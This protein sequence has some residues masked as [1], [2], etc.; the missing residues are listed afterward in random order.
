MF[1]IGERSIGDGVRPVGAAD[2]RLKIVVRRQ[3]AATRNWV[4]VKKKTP[5]DGMSCTVCH[6]TCIAETKESLA[7]SSSRSSLRASNCAM[8]YSR[9]LLLRQHDVAPRLI[10]KGV[11][12]DVARH[13]LH[14]TIAGG[15]RGAICPARAS[16]NRS[17][18]SDIRQLAA[19]YRS[20]AP[21]HKA[22]G[23][24]SIQRF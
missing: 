23:V 8:I 10:D 21:V 20:T 16:V 1:G 12:T 13:V 15:T 18:S 2:R 5:V 3:V 14:T 24:R 9:H 11:V 17:R 4:D 7:L 6:T 19:R 22:S